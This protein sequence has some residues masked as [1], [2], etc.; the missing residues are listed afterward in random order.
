MGG[1]ASDPDLTL[2]PWKQQKSL[3]SR[4]QWDRLPPALRGAGEERRGEE[5]RGEERGEERRDST[6]LGGQD[7]S[8]SCWPHR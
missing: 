5:R 4:A 8:I 7:V 6:G 2:T 1:G 3:F